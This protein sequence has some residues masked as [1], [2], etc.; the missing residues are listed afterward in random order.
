ETPARPTRLARSPRRPPPDR[1]WTLG[2]PGAA[3]GGRPEAL[4]VLDQHLG[5]LVVLPPDV[6]GVVGAVELADGAARALPLLDDGDGPRDAAVAHQ[7]ERR[8]LHRDAVER[9]RV[10][11]IDAARALLELHERL[12]TLL[13]LHLLAEHADGVEDGLVGAHDAAGATVDAQLR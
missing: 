2:G 4:V 8:R 11:A 5:A 1:A 12:G 13:G 3:R 6:D 7:R 9:A 10:D